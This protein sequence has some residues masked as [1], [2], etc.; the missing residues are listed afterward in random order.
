MNYLTS[1]IV[2]FKTICLFLLLPLFLFC[3]EDAQIKVDLHHPYYEEG[4]LKTREGGVIKTKDMRIQAKE[5]TYVKREGTWRVEAKQDVLVHYMGKHFVGD[6]LHYNFITRSGELQGGRTQVGCW[7]LGGERIKL[8]SDG[9]YQLKGIYLT[10][11]EG[12][13]NLWQYYIGSGRVENQDLL[14]AKNVQV[15]L[16]HIP[17]FWFPILR[18]KLST[19]KDAVAKYEF[20]TGG[21]TGERL[22]MRYQIYSWRDLKVFLQGDYWFTR[23]PGFSLQFDYDKSSLPL[24]F[25]ANNF[26]AFDY[27]GVHPYGIFRYRYVGE[28]S[29]ILFDALE[30]SGEY[31]K[32]SD[33][34]VLQTYFNRDYFLSIER[35]SKLQLRLARERWLGF[36]RTEVRINPFDIVSQELPLF[37][38]NVKPIQVARSPLYLDLNLNVGYLDYVYGNVL[39]NSPENFRSARIE[40]HPRVTM[41]L[42]FGPL[43]IS[44]SAEYIGIGYGQSIQKDALWSSLG[45]FSSRAFVT[46]SK[47][48]SPKL[49]HTIEPYTRYDYYSRPTVSFREHYLF[50][51]QDAYVKLNQ[52][53]WGIETALFYKPKE[54]IYQPLNLDVYSYGFFNNQTIGSFIPKMYLTLSSKW[55]NLNVELQSGYNLQH[56]Q[57]DF[58]ASRVAYTFSE[59]FAISASYFH[60]SRYA[61]RKADL[62]SFFLDV[63]RPQAEL[64][65][66]PL[67]DPRDNL[68][69]TLYF[70][71]LDRVIFQFKSRTGWNQRLTPYYNEVFFT[72]TLLL[73]CNWRFHFTP[74]RTVAEGWRWEFSFELGKAPPEAPEAPFICW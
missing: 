11:C 74:R 1:A 43:S 4:V 2:R 34:N 70:R 41:P 20:I 23:G 73:P 31:D 22:G 51:T 14:T 60:Y 48:F 55:P 26:S 63:F 45:H 66:S 54:Q 39:L 46:L 50:N 9:S 40:L 35:R 57:I 72:L 29:G 33:D 27:H 30:F 47:S 28:F 15:Q 65:A 42:H 8:T 59:R 16:F 44:S 67:S 3:D 61:Y 68:L 58:A 62:D 38:L 10:T 36:M 6:Q 69:T 21:T 13:S 25:K 18:A 64:L 24:M 52:L 32:L 56:N 71:P 5:I 19:L 53:R 7:F 37:F 49:K 17:I 12:P